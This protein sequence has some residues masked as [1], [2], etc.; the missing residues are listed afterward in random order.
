MKHVLILLAVILCCSSV[1]ADHAWDIVTGISEAEMKEVA[2]DPTK[3][4][5]IYASS[6]KKM[7][8]SENS[9]ESWTVVFTA[10]EDGNS[11][12]FVAVSRKAVFVCTERGAFKS[13]DGK[14]KWKKVFKG[15]GAKENNV[16]HVAFSRNGDIYLGTRRGLF[17]SSDN[18]ATWKKD[19]DLSVKWVAFLGDHDFLAA[20][21]GVYKGRE[22]K[23]KRVFVTAVEE[24]EYDSDEADY[25][26]TSTKPVNSIAID[27]GKIYLATDSGIFTSS[28]TGETWG[29]FPSSGLLSQKIKRLLF[30][31]D[32][33]AA[34]DKGIF[35]FNKKDQSWTALYKGMSANKAYSLSIDSNKRIWVAT[36]KGLHNT[37]KPRPSLGF[38]DEGDVFED[39]DYEPTIREIQEAAIEYAEVHPDK[40]K[41]WRRGARM[42]PLLPEV[43]V[44]YDK[45]INYDSGADRYYTGPHD[46][47]V[48]AKWD[49][50]EIIWNPNQTTIDIR[51]KL[52][53]QLR[54]DVLDEIT[55]T[56]FER[57]R[58]QIELELSP[59]TDIKNKMESALRV[60]ELTAD[61]D[62]MTGGYFSK[63]IK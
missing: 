30:K 8:R 46:W 38:F 22:G 52:M 25:A 32:L 37:K 15:V 34:T 33:Y 47:G 40:I 31:D 43:S 53:V 63:S 55:R 7:Y 24:S 19:Q 61:L 14:S 17:I 13:I 4:G 58:L 5:V 62:A 3:V 18:C 29:V 42:K 50:G 2:V 9:G 16:S 35:I 26:A 6:E 45:T 20:E 11:I 48:S 23:W 56:Y 39:F 54:D 12:N 41:N 44:D 27:K 49:L 60:E 57:R 51:S 28:N 21:T 59:P 1:F 10:R 36:D